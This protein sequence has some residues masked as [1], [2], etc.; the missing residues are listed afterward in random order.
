MRF[1]ASWP[2]TVLNTIKVAYRKS[3]GRFFSWIVGD[4]PPELGALSAVRTHG[5]VRSFEAE[6][7][8]A[9]GFGEHPFYCGN[10]IVYER[11]HGCILSDCGRTGGQHV[12]REWEE[13]ERIN[14]TG[15]PSSPETCEVDYVDNW[16]IDCASYF[17]P[18]AK[19]SWMANGGGLTSAGNPGRTRFARNRIVQSHP[20]GGGITIYGDRPKIDTYLTHDGFAHGDVV[21]EEN[22]VRCLVGASAAREA[23]AIDDCRSL[24]WRANKLTGSEKRIKIGPRI[25][26]VNDLDGTLP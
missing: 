24:T 12:N 17:D 19:S 8:S 10:T 11:V 13:K 2:N 4:G 7:C 9:D 23:I 18:K 3:L 25:G 22:E 6:D 26:K 20:G 1:V 21:V 5:A 15:C 14:K 16:I